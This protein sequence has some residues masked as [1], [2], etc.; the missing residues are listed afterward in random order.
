MLAHGAPYQWDRFVCGHPGDFYATGSVPYSE[1]MDYF[2][3]KYYDHI[4]PRVTPGARQRNVTERKQRT[5]ASICGYCSKYPTYNHMRHDLGIPKSTWESDGLQTLFNLAEHMDEIIPYSHAARFHPYNH[6]VHMPVLVTSTFDMGPIDVLSSLDRLTNA[7]TWNGK[8]CRSGE[9]G[10]A[11]VLLGGRLREAPSR[12]RSRSLRARALPLVRAAYKIGLNVTLRGEVA[13]VI[14]PRTSATSDT[15]YFNR[16]M[17][18][19]RWMPRLPHEWTLGDGA[20]LSCERC[21]CPAKKRYRRRRERAARPEDFQDDDGHLI[22]GND[23]DE[24][25]LP[26]DG[27]ETDDRLTPEEAFLNTIIQNY[28]SRSEHIMRDVFVPHHVFRTQFRGRIGHVDNDTCRC[29]LCTLTRFVVNKTAVWRRWR[30]P[31]GAYAASLIGPWGHGA[32][33]LGQ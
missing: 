17:A 3:E 16:S 5:L 15:T 10:D 25:G 33:E 26:L 32:L 20:F 4:E 23:D 2:F 6:A 28:R 30:G 14:W 18:V 22:I 1:V 21:L 31:V 7:A 24:R 27:L 29:H 9:R 11:R 13:G 19:S 12:V 8:Y